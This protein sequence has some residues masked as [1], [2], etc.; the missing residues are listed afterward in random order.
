MTF[1]I[2]IFVIKFKYDKMN[3]FVTQL[4]MKNVHKRLLNL[5]KFMKH[6]ASGS[7]T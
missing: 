7:V 2:Y 6:G 5:I 3:A 1:K 4:R